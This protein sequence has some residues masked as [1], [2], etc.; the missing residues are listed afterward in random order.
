MGEKSTSTAICRAQ[1]I[2]IWHTTH[3]YV[4]RCSLFV[5]SL[6]SR[7]SFC[8]AH[9]SNWN[10]KKKSSERD[11][12]DKNDGDDKDVLSEIQEE[13]SQTCE[14]GGYKR[15]PSC[16][17]AINDLIARNCIRSNS[18]WESREQV[19]EFRVQQPHSFV[20]ARKARVLL[21]AFFCFSSD[22]LSLSPPSSAVLQVERGKYA[23]QSE[24]N[25]F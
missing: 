9:I 4:F 6:L 14:S 10:E 16:S 8:S 5:R 20:C 12:D 22:F 3:F 13:S 11:D 23:Y 25:S 2:V 1:K 24:G 19:E 18:S 17:Y 15:M 21:F 7:S